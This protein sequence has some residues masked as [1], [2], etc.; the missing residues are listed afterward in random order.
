MCSLITEFAP[1][2]PGRSRIDVVSSR[3]TLADIEEAS[4]HFAP[5][6]GRWPL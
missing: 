2:Q 6:K 3:P 4:L 5:L 1:F